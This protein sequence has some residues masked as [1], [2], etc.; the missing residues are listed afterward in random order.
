MSPPLLERTAIA[1]A[2]LPPL[3]PLLSP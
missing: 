2:L 1:I 3:P